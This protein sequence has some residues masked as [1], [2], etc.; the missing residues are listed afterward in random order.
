V[1]VTIWIDKIRMA[2]HMD[3]VGIWAE[4]GEHYFCCEYEFRK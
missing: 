1:H 2:G 3:V 4:C